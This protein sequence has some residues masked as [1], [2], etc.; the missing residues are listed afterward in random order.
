MP[1]DIGTSTALT[2]VPKPQPA[3]LVCPT[4]KEETGTKKEDVLDKLIDS[5]FCCPFC[6][7]VVFSCRPE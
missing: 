1:I 5:D 4:C 6:G 7:S 2:V 3:S